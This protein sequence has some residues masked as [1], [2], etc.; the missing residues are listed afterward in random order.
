MKINFRGFARFLPIIKKIPLVRSLVSFIAGNFAFPKKKLEGA[1]A[2]YEAYVYDGSYVEEKNFQEPHLVKFLGKKLKKGMVF[3]DIGAHFGYYTLL[4]RKLV[5]KSGKVIAFEPSPIPYKYLSKNIKINKFSNAKANQLLVGK[6]NGE[7]VL[8]YSGFGGTKS[9]FKRSSDLPFSKKV[10][11]IALDSFVSK[12]RH[13]P[14]FVKID[15][16]GAELLVLQGFLKTIEGLKPDLLIELH[17]HLLSAGDLEKILT[18]LKD[19]NY[20]L[21]SVEAKEDGYKLKKFGKL[22]STHHLYATTNY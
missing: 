8:Y 13:D 20:K 17:H 22:N 6:R 5:G 1:L 3:Y 12:N 18:I 15:V 4:A 11:S 9:S 16:E 14:D 2:G 7:S 10:S 19:S 21:F